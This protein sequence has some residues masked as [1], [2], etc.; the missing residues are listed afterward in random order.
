ME[1]CYMKP[2]GTDPKPNDR[3]YFNVTLDSEDRERMD[4]M[5]KAEQISRAQVVR[6]ALTLR[7]IMTI[8]GVPMCASGQRCFVPH[9]HP[10]LPA[11][12][13]SA[14]ARPPHQRPT[15]QELIA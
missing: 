5:A 11:A 2:T 10:P 1:N 7:W 15:P 9:M 4:A 14:L 13:A 12:S 8:S 3:F 6:A